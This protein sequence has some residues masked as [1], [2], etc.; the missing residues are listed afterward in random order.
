MEISL[1]ADAVSVATHGLGFAKILLRSHHSSNNILAVV[2]PMD[3]ISPPTV[4]SHNFRSAP[5]T[6][7]RRM[8]RTRRRS[9]TEEEG[10]DGGDEGFFGNGDGPFGGGG[11]SGRGWNF[12]GFGGSNWE[13]SSSSPYSDPAFDFVYGVLCWIVFSNCMHFAFKRAVQIAAG[14]VG[15][16]SREK[17]PMRLVPSV[18]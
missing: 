12:D 5:R 15:D 10:V 2:L 14:G 1:I 6:L 9:L 3:A 17:V 16:P 11:G 18:C 13:E 8:R 4:R 7:V